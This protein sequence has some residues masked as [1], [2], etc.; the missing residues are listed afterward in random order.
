MIFFRAD[1]APQ[2]SIKPVKS[3]CG[4]RGRVV[5]TRKIAYFLGSAHPLRIHF[6]SAGKARRMQDEMEAK[7][8]GK[9]GDRV[10]KIVA[11]SDC[12][13]AATSHPSFVR[14]MACL[15]QGMV[16]LQVNLVQ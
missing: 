1:P 14:K 7:P 15:F 11:D 13:H 3:P 6:A 10:G 8:S 5:E 9:G 16:N 4:L 12:D 2:L